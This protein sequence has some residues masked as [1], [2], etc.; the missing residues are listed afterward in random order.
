M[1]LWTSVNAI[2]SLLLLITLALFAIAFV[3]TVRGA[4]RT[5]VALET[6]ALAGATR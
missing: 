1:L 4:R 2:S 5:G 3:L 6:E